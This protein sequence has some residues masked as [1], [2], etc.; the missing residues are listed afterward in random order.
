MGIWN[1]NNINTFNRNLIAQILCLM[2]NLGLAID[3]T[4]KNTNNFK[5]EPGF[6]PIIDILK[7]DYRRHRISLRNKNILFLEQLTYKNIIEL[8]RLDELNLTFRGRKPKW[9]NLIKEKVTKNDITLEIKDEYKDNLKIET[10]EKQ[11][12]PTITQPIFS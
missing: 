11:L 6:I 8:K 12:F 7:Y 1:Y 10:E 5:I 9:W 3:K 4:T 2:N